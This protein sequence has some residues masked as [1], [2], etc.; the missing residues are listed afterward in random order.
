MTEFTLPVP[1]DWRRAEPFYAGALD[2]ALTVLRDPRT[3]ERLVRYYE[4]QSNYAGAT[5][6]QLTDDAPTRVT[7]RDL[8]AVSLLDVTVPPATVRALLEDGGVRE[9]VEELLS[10]DRLPV[11]AKLEEVTPELLAAMDDLYTT[12]RSLV[13]PARD[14]YAVNWV[15]AAKLCA[16]KRPDLFPVRD[17]VVCRYLG[18]WPSRY[19]IDWQVFAYVIGQQEVRDRLTRLITRTAESDAVDVGN[20]AHLLRHLDVCIWMHAPHTF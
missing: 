15:T 1:A 18:T 8:L 20:P 7:E 9:K 14:R 11:D 16:R 4:R 13:P 5:F 17:E 19:Q 6:T 12:L 2:R 3:P 10:L